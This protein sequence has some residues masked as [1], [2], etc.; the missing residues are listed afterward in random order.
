M[1]NFAKDLG[2]G[3]CSVKRQWANG[4]LVLGLLGFGLG[5]SWLGAQSQK[6]V[7]IRAAQLF[8]GKS[9]RLASNQ[10]SASP[11]WG[12]PRAL[13]SLPG[14]RKSIWERARCCRA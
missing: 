13:R 1:R 10:V 7:V 3:G 8:D 2:F 14:R 11:R 6:V 9:D 4:F 5:G 12:R